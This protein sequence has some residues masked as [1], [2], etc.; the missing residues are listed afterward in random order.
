LIDES[1]FALSLGSSRKRFAVPFGEYCKGR[2]EDTRRHKIDEAGLKVIPIGVR[3]MLKVKEMFGA[4]WEV[5]VEVAYASIR[6]FLNYTCFRP[7]AR[8]AC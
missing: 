8:F 5:F 4:R 2:L 6:A 1:S 7:R 3:V